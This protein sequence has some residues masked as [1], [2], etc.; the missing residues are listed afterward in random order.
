MGAVAD[1]R[2]QVDAHD[3]FPARQEPIGTRL[4]AWWARTLSTPR[5]RALWY[6]GGPLLVRAPELPTSELEGMSR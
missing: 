1:E 4:D 3:D 6:W 5:R 2:E